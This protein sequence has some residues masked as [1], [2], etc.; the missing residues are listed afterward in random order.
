MEIAKRDYGTVKAMAR[1]WGKV[2][3]TKAV[4]QRSCAV[5]IFKNNWLKNDSPFAL[6]T[7]V[8]EADLRKIKGKM[9]VNPTIVQ[10]GV[11]TV[12]EVR[13]L[14]KSKKKYQNPAMYSLIC[15]G[16]ES[17]KFNQNPRQDPTKISNLLT[18][19]HEAIIR[20]ELHFALGQQNFRHNPTRDHVDLRHAQWK[21]FCDLVFDDLVKIMKKMLRS[22]G[23]VLFQTALAAMMMIM[24][25]MMLKHWT[26]NTLVELSNTYF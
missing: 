16:V 18:V 7:N 4:N 9:E 17:G 14:L 13:D 19:A 1:E 12:G 2:I 6:V 23:S 11:T 26:R 3:L 20:L 24:M 15:G 21:L 8:L 22:R 25:M 10:T 5:T